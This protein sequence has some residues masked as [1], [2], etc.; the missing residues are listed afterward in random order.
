[1]LSSPNRLDCLNR[2]PIEPT[3]RMAAM[4]IVAVAAG[5][6]AC[7]TPPLPGPPGDSC[8]DLNTNRVGD[9]AEDVNTDGRVD[10]AD[11]RG[12][13]GPAGGA[14]PVGPQG[15]DGPPGRDGATIVV[16]TVAELRAA[17]ANV[18]AGGGRIVMLQ[19]EYVLD[20]AV[21]IDRDNLIIE[22]QGAGTLVRLGDHVNQ[23]CFILGSAGC[24]DAA[25]PIRRNLALRRLRIDGNRANQDSETDGSCR[26]NNCI[27][28]RR[29][30]DTTVEDVLLENARSGAIVAEKGCEN[31]LLDRITAQNCFFDGIA[32]YVTTRSLII[33]CTSRNNLA[34]GL[35]CDLGFRDC[36]VAHC[37]F[38]SNGSVGVFWRDSTGNLLADSRISQ[39]SQDGI[40]IADGDTGLPA[41]ANVFDCNFYTNNGRHGFWQAGAHSTGNVLDG[42]LFQGNSQSAIEE[43]FPATAPLIRYNV[44]LLP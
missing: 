38:V 19:G 22:G 37:L 40:F 31:L 4:L 9:A 5:P 23:P 14:G 8:W 16:S 41:S 21:V 3:R 18:P 20:G 11:C 6:M 43:S 1:M 29:C 39:N 2:P 34:A 42:G 28:V 27:S 10:V 26:R 44:T 15:P 17:I 13:Q 24:D 35:S 7:Q 36:I 12:P 30:V 32:L 33:N 25:L